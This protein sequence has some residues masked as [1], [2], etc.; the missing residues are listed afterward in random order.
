M[1]LILGGSGQL[2]SSFRRVLPDA[3]SPPHSELDVTDTAQLDRYLARFTPEL[4]INCCGYTNVDGAEDDPD[5]AMAVN[6]K[7][8]GA[9]ANRADL[10]GIPF[11]T[12]SSDYVFDG[13]T[14]SP[15]V[16][17]SQPNPINA[18]GRSKEAGERL[19]L[20]YRGSL[21]IRTSWLF[22]ETHPNFVATILRLVTAGKPVRVV[23][24]QFGCP[25]HVDVLAEA[26]MRAVSLCVNGVLHL[27]SGP[28]VSWY[29]L[30]QSTTAAAGLDK[31]TVTS[32]LSGEFPTRAS[33]PLWSVLGSELPVDDMGLRLPEWTEVLPHTVAELIRHKR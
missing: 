1:E 22:S 5:Q 10:L 2:G 21:V 29:Q 33:R 3:I 12:F 20:Q 19:A 4:I 24:D 17:S 31:E 15:Y 26:T 6:G 18:Y 30:A 32:C 16:E 27:A 25:T 8:V 11:V 9:L 7:A 14:D 23:D 28:A 13:R